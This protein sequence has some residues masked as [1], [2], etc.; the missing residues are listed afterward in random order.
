[1]ELGLAILIYANENKG[2]FPRARF[3][4]ANAETVHAFTGGKSPNLVLVSLAHW[5]WL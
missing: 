1:M 3:D 5:R 2:A 4:T